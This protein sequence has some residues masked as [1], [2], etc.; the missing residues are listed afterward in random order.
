MS[1]H[2]QRDERYEIDD[3]EK[4]RALRTLAVLIEEQ[5]PPGMGFGLLM[6]DFGPK[7]SMFW[8]SNADRADMVKVMREWIAK[9]EGATRGH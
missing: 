5:L 8:I 2:P 9:Q 3:P 7:G 1:T 4:K 6:F